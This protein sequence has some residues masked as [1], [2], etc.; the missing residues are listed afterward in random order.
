MKSV[1]AIAFDYRPSRG[2]LCGILIMAVL[3]SVAIALCGLG[4][5]WKLG[6]VALAAAYMGW[7]LRKFLY[8]PF[9]RI[10]WHSAGHWRLH[11]A[12]GRE[13]VGEFVRAVV[14]GVLTV[15]VL[16]TA[17]TRAVAFVLLPDNCDAETQRKLRVRLARANSR[18]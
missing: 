17:A 10:V 5:A 18:E 15:L 1:P 2:L 8:R 9:V 3:A 11:D 16:K 13:Q 7:A 12:H 14:L 4:M 6:L